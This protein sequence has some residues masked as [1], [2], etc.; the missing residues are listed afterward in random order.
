MTYYATNAGA[1]TG[2]FNLTSNVGASKVDLK[3]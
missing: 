3:S 1:S 2:T